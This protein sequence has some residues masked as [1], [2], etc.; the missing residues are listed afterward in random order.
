MISYCSAPLSSSLFRPRL[1]QTL[2]F[3][4]LGFTLEV[5]DNHDSEQAQA[6]CRQDPWRE[7]VLRLRSCIFHER[8]ETQRKADDEIG[9]VAEVG[10][11]GLGLFG[12]DCKGTHDNEGET[13]L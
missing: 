9:A 3:V 1:C 2:V 6:E 12:E 7:S 13:G 8:Q 4:C 5:V 10:A 11:D